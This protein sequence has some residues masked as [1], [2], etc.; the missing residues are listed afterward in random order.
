M[1]AKAHLKHSWLQRCLP[2]PGRWRLMCPLR[3]LAAPCVLALACLAAPVTVR[4]GQASGDE[5][6]F[7]KLWHSWK[8]GHASTI[9]LSASSH[10]ATKTAAGSSPRVNSGVG[11]R[12]NPVVGRPMFHAGVDLA[13]RTG[14]G[15][16]ATA[17]G[18]VT[19]AGLRGG[20]GLLVIVTHDGGYETRYAHLSRITTT[21]GARVE[22][23]TMVGLVGST[24]RSTGPHLHYEVRRYG[25]VLDPVRF[26]AR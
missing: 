19:Y 6:A 8:K 21:N 11:M 1:L 24:G 17:E 15:V 18:I 9:P 25:R 7:E 4:A 14:K 23:G 13:A 16:C 2:L 22:R 12:L 10:P 26:M 5:A 3:R 20:Y